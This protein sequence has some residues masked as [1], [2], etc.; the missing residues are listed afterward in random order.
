MKLISFLL[1]I[2]AGLPTVEAQ[3]LLVYADPLGDEV[4]K[5][6]GY[7]S[8]LEFPV[9]VQRDIDPKSGKITGATVIYDKQ[10]DEVFRAS[11]KKLGN[12][13]KQWKDNNDSLQ[14]LWKRMDDHIVITLCLDTS[15]LEGVGGKTRMM[16][17]RLNK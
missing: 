9:I 1:F 11:V 13:T 8:D 5:T 14:Y 7:E 10:L 4:E 6:A 2:G 15:V 3:D 16:Y 17:L 12:P